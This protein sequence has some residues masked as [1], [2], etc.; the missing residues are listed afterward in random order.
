VSKLR[1]FQNAWCKDGKKAH[2]SN[3]ILSS[4]VRK[5][6]ASQWQSKFYD[7]FWCLFA[8]I[9]YLGEDGQYGTKNTIIYTRHNT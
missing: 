2:Y 8:S 3:S 9:N 6:P 7:T 1:R 4:I 5:A